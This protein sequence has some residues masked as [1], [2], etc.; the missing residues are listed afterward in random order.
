MC[1]YDDL[2][3]SKVAEIWQ[4]SEKLAVIGEDT[5]L[6]VELCHLDYMATVSFVGYWKTDLYYKIPHIPEFT[7]PRA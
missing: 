1:L 5:L 3:N 4:G 6:Q 2:I 7:Y